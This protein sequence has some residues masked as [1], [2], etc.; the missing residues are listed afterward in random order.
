MGG[1]G[2]GDGRGHLGHSGGV[3]A[4][5]A[6][7][8]SGS[9]SVK[10]AVVRS[11]P[12][13]SAK[14]HD[15]TESK[16]EPRHVSSNNS[17]AHQHHQYLPHAGNNSTAAVHTTNSNA[18]RIAAAESAPRREDYLFSN[19]LEAA[20]PYFVDFG[21][22][23]DSSAGDI[24]AASTGTGAA[25]PMEPSNSTEG[26]QKMGVTSSTTSTTNSAATTPAL[27]DGKQDASL[28]MLDDFFTPT[29]MTSRPAVKSASVRDRQ[30]QHSQN[31]HPHHHQPFQQ[32]LQVSSLDF[33]SSL[34]NTLPSSS[35]RSSTR[36]S[37]SSSPFAQLASATP[38]PS[39]PALVNDY[40][41]LGRGNSYT[42][43]APARKT[44]Q[45]SANTTA[46]T[47]L[48]SVPPASAPLSPEYS[49][50]GLNGTMDTT[51]SLAPPFTPASHQRRKNNVTVPPSPLTSASFA[52]T[53]SSAAG[54]SNEPTEPK[55]FS[56][57]ASLS[58]NSTAAPALPSA[59][60]GLD[61]SSYMDPI[62]F[63]APAPPMST[64]KPSAKVPSHPQH[65]P[66]QPVS[67]AGLKSD[68]LFQNHRQASQHSSSRRT[69]PAPVSQPF[70]TTIQ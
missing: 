58:S 8:H 69:V 59:D 16:P 65:A 2:G 52:S 40:S 1:A 3:S 36:S 28:S 23:N 7:G 20:M 43:T 60:S 30:E 46:Y 64:P 44:S 45:C 41:S 55:A 13:F 15:S 6:S 68:P 54:L 38:L 18:R 27:D 61:F 19:D 17:T 33:F 9:T 67:T 21:N 34:E 42:R 37:S 25:A 47:S 26:R 51:A 11:S 31:Q 35:T 29:L 22:E 24:F 49:G 4:G 39:F 5:G 12:S 48:E 14:Q 62:A 63:S 57:T 10:S 66:R 70:K 32:T 53:T 56:S 50:L